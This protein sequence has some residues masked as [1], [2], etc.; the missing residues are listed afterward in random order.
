MTDHPKLPAGFNADDLNGDEID[1]SGTN[2]PCWPMFFDSFVGFKPLLL[3]ANDLAMFDTECPDYCVPR[4]D[5]TVCIPAE[6][7]VIEVR[8]RA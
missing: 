2:W 5:D 1:G 3:D 6:D 8:K 4:V 7:D